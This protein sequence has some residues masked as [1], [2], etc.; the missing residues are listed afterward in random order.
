MIRRLK[1]KIIFLYHYA[2]SLNRRVEV[3][4]YLL[5]C[6]NGKTPLPDHDKCKELALKLGTP[7]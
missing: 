4:Q 5:N 1:Y 6:A 2:K 7:E 3:E